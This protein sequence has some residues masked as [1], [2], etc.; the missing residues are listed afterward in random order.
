MVRQYLTQ[1][2]PL[3]RKIRRAFE[4][5]DKPVFAFMNVNWHKSTNDNVMQLQS[6]FVPGVRHI[7]PFGVHFLGTMNDLGGPDFYAKANDAFRSKTTGSKRGRDDTDA[8][9]GLAWIDVAA[10]RFQ[11]GGPGPGAP[12]R[13]PPPLDSDRSAPAQK[14]PPVWPSTTART[15]GSAAA[16]RNPSCSAVTRAVESALRLCGESR[17]SRATA[18]SVLKPTGVSVMAG[19]R[20][21]DR[22]RPSEVCATKLSTI[23]R[24]TGAIRDSRDDASMAASPYSWERPLPPSDCTA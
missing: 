1:P 3:G 23:S 12:A 21:Y 14:V 9:V 7:A 17:V 18:P 5:D 13:A 6:V 22:G 20:Q 11:A 19:P 8:R 10:G 24:L 4:T 2:G 15:A 16:L